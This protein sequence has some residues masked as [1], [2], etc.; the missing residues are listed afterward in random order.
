M[1]VIKVPGINGLGKTR[2]TRDAGNTIIEETGKGKLLDLEEIHLDNNNLQAQEKLIYENSKEAF[3]KNDKTFFLGGDHSITYSTCRAFLETFKESFLIVFD[4]HADCMPALQ[5]PTHEEWLRKL[6]EKGWKPENV[7]LV[8]LRKIEPEELAFLN[9]NRIRYFEMR[10]IENKEDICDL[11]MEA[12]HGR[13]LYVSFDI[14]V[15]DPAFAPGT[16]YQEPGGFSSQDILYFARRIS[17]MKN[18]KAVDIVEVFA[19]DKMTVKLAA[20]TLEEFL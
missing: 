9:G 8:G 2:K 17:R 10:N 7:V 19:E 4:A 6:V 16:G 1:Q 18:L 15:V 20:R 5:E 13:K 3:N 14:D 11:I 12:S